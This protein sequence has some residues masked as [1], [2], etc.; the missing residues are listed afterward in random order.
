VLAVGSA[1]TV[2]QGS[3]SGQPV[4]AGGQGAAGA[5]A[6]VNNANQSFP[7]RVVEAL[8]AALPKIEFPLTVR[9]GK[10]LTAAEMVPIIQSETS[11]QKFSLVLWQTGTVEAVRS[12]RPDDLRGALETGVQDVVASGSDLILIDPQFSRFL[13]SNTDLD[14][15]E[16]VLQETAAMPDVVLF[17]RF[18]LMRSWANSGG[19]DL[20]RTR[21]PDQMAAMAAL[22]ACLGKALAQF[23][24]N[25][26]NVQSP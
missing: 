23:I 15:Y 12:M 5:Q 18:D 1:T 7:Y 11:E 6:E 19:L 14:P 26:V 8:H 13:R 16:H 20:E 10:G 24:L 25:G 17:R 4:A 9:G 3:A 22:H 21:K 2:G